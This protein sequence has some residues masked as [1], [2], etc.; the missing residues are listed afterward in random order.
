ME[1]SNSISTSSNE[2]P[3]IWY[4]VKFFNKE[5]YAD[6]FIKGNLHLNRLR[7]FRKTESSSDDG[8]PDEYEAISHWWQPKDFKINLTVP[9]VGE[10]EIKSEDLAG[11]VSMSF[12]Y[13]ENLHV[14]CLYA[15]RTFGFEIIDG[16]ID[17]AEGDTEAL[18]K[19]LEVDF[20]NFKLGDFAVI[21]PA[22]QFLDRLREVLQKR[23]QYFKGR[24]VE[25]YDDET[26]HGATEPDEIP[27][28][29][30][31]NFSYQNEFRICVNTKTTGDDPLK[32][33][34]GDISDI[35]Q[36][37]QSDK[38]NDLLALQSIKV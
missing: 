24:L 15:I 25:Y 37:I 23:G 3:A 31:K 21:T 17:Y 28:W 26:F 19:Q 20:R 9:G 2:S 22:P 4:L 8:R 14:F 11:P 30:Q 27:F 16:K 36:K 10:V 12:D 13:H 5:E 1:T 38:I 7:Y 33:D 35:C 18:Q 29:K 6:A 34:M 32:I